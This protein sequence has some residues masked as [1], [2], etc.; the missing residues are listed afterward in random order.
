MLTIGLFLDFCEIE[1]SKQSL[2][3]LDKIV[4]AV[5]KR[6]IHQW[7]EKLKR[8]IEKELSFE[9]P[10]CYNSTGDF[11][12]LENLL[13]FDDDLTNDRRLDA[14][15]LQKA[16]EDTLEKTKIASDPSSD[17]NDDHETISQGSPEPIEIE[18]NNTQPT[19]FEEALIEIGNVEE[20]SDNEEEDDGGIHERTNPNPLDLEKQTKTEEKIPETQS[21]SSSKGALS[22]DVNLE[23]GSS[24]SDSI[25]ACPFCDYKT[26]KIKIYERH[27]NSHHQCEKCEKSFHGMNAK[28]SFDRHMKSHEPKRQKEIKMVSCS[29]C[30]NA[31]GLKKAFKSGWLL[32]RHLKTHKPKQE[33]AEIKPDFDLLDFQPNSLSYVTASSKNEST[34]VKT[35]LETES[36]SVLEHSIFS[37]KYFPAMNLETP[38]IITGKHTSPSK[39]ED[40]S[41]NK[42]RKQNLN[43]RNFF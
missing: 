25:F 27:V 36:K 4:N 39:L 34:I 31:Y 13:D 12:K 24:Q 22:Q 20:S 21:S 32:N 9:C 43:Q 14:Q 7:L 15:L 18:E 41:K 30:Q 35:E 28:R 6:N 33:V 11:K 10:A 42:R 40:D 19:E 26:E 8:K 38:S 29:I 3:K 37:E 2:S 17:D 5:I 16:A 23:S 1:Y